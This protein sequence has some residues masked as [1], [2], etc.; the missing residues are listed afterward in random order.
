[1]KALDIKTTP[2][3][4]GLNTFTVHPLQW[5]LVTGDQGKG[6]EGGKELFVCLLALFAEKLLYVRVS[7]SLV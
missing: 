4:V 5:L 1:M 3:H 7:H 2:V 6:K